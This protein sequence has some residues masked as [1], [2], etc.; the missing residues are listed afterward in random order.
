MQ[1]N[2]DPNDLLRIRRG[3]SQKSEMAF[4]VTYQWPFPGIPYNHFS[5]LTSETSRFLPLCP[6]LSYF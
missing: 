5:F 1:L 3:T 2:E 4:T 6:L